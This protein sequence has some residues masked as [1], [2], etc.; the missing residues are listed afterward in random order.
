MNEWMNEWDTF[1][2]NPRTPPNVWV[3]AV[4]VAIRP[5]FGTKFFFFIFRHSP[6]QSDRV[7]SSL[8]CLNIFIFV[9]VVIK[10]CKY[11]KLRTMRRPLSFGIITKE[12]KVMPCHLL[13]L[14][15]SDRKFKLGRSVEDVPYYINWF[16]CQLIFS[17]LYSMRFA[18]R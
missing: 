13:R 16:I 9:Q 2:C 11:G 12:T 15:S 18:Y 10:H 3:K 5:R 14:E 8:I 4:F 1:E 6:V 17:S 7:H